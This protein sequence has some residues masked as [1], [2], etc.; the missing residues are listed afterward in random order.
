MLSER[1]RNAWYESA[2]IVI[3]K[4]VLESLVE[5]GCG[6]VHLISNI[7]QAWNW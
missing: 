5:M 4:L 3:F 2:F 6:Q 7:R 1:K